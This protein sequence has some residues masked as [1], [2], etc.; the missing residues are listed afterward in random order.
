MRGK[1]ASL[2]VLLML[3]PIAARADVKPNAI[4]TDGMVLQQ[5]AKV[6]VW[7]TAD[8]GEKVTITFRD[9][10]TSAHGDDKGTWIV[11]LESGA[12]AARCR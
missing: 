3:A 1:V 11:T 9:K 12:P 6:H 2:A 7:G 5:K 10:E 4:C 8:K